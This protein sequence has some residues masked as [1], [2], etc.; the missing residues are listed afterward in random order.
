[1]GTPWDIE[2]R[3]L[4][5]CDLWPGSYPLT[6]SGEGHAFAESNHQIKGIGR[7]SDRSEKFPS[8]AL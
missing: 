5:A 7:S 1:M 2:Y 3:S 4:V 6:F 8:I